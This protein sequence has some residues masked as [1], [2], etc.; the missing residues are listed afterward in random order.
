MAAQRGRVGAAVALDPRNGHVLALASTPGYDDNIYGPPADTTSLHQLAN[1]AG[2]P[3]R[4]HAA[5]SALPPGSTFKL[6][7]ATAN[8]IHP[9]WRPNQVVPTGASF[10]LGGHTFHNW[11]PMGPMNL[12]HALAWSNDVYFY[13]L[14][15]ALGPDALVEAARALGVGARTGIDLPAES[16]GYLGTPASVRQDGATWYPGSTVIMGIGQGYLAV[17][18]LQN[19]CWTAAVVTGH[20]IT[21]R[22]GLATGAADTWA[23]VPTPPPRQLPFASAL[24]PIQEGMRSAVTAGTAT[25]LA[26]LPAPVGAKTGTAQ[27]GSLPDGRYDNW[28]TAVAPIDDPS[29]VVTILTQVANAATAISHD[30][31]AY[32]LAH[33]AD[34]D[35]TGPTQGP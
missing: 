7:V 34:I 26:D 33:K 5:Q 27:D 29:L 9:V 23:A 19:A 17:T 21:P 30:A 14:A 32:Y 22:L 24:A 28:I 35:R 25:R 12:L 16:P 2:S 11:K 1:T 18:P 20:L 13:K 10:S 6:V 8:Q 4:N 31:L 3:M 15:Y